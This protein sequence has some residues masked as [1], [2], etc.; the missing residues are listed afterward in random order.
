MVEQPL[1]GW[2]EEQEIQ[3]QTEYRELQKNYRGSNR[4]DAATL[5]DLDEKTYCQSLVCG[6]F[7]LADV[8]PEEHRACFEAC[9]DKCLNTSAL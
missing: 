7:A 4:V 1:Y 2:T 9:V 8:N 6:A 5:S 3:L